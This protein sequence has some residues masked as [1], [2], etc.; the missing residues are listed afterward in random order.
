MLPHVPG[1]PMICHRFLWTCVDFH[2]CASNF[3]HLLMICQSSHPQFLPISNSPSQDTSLV[4]HH[5]T[6]LASCK[7]MI[8]PPRHYAPP[9]QAQA[10]CITASAYAQDSLLDWDV[11]HFLVTV[12]SDLRLFVISSL[13]LLSLP[14]SRVRSSVMVTSHHPNIQTSKLGTAECA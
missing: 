14:P 5:T 9:A 7:H 1:F 6:N 13:P 11:K 4:F 3:M 2:C 12:I 10:L 8:A